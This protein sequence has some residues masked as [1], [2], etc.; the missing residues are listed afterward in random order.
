MKFFDIRHRQDHERRIGSD[1]NRAQHGIRH[2]PVAAG[3]RDGGVPVG[4][5]RAA[6]QQHLQHI[7]DEPGADDGEGDPGGRLEGLGDEDAAVE[8][9]VG[10]FAQEEAERVEELAGEEDLWGRKRN[11]CISVSQSLPSIMVLC[12]WWDPDAV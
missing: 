4:R 10:G 11:T 2:G 8:E 12:L 6:N 1:V 9:D 5:D 3:R 7:A